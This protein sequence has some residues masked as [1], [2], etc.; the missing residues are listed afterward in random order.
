M[1]DWPKLRAT[2][3]KID[4]LE[5]Q[6]T[7]LYA[8]RRDIILDMAAEGMTR[9]EIATHWRISNPRVT[10]IINGVRADDACPIS[11]CGAR[12]D[13]HC[14]SSNGRIRSDHAARRRH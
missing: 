13:D 8:Q 1:I 4:R 9:R 14:V 11:F 6:L 3:R 5:Q 10:T 2:R 7:D 12:G